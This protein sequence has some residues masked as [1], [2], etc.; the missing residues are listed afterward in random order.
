MSARK[1]FS[2]SG[3]VIPEDV[4]SPLLAMS[5]FRHAVATTSKQ[6]MQ[7]DDV[8]DLYWDSE[9]SEIA[10]DQSEVHEI[11][12][13]RSDT[14]FSYSGV[15]DNSE[16]NE[17]MSFSFTAAFFVKMTCHFH[18][19]VSRPS[20]SM[21][22][23]FSVLVGSKSSSGETRPLVSFGPQAL[24]VLESVST[25]QTAMTGWFRYFA[26]TRTMGHS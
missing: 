20:E 13:D 11:D 26:R 7:D 3:I 24:K 23:A 19:S 21:H 5:S 9:L 15:L 6:N 22:G 8:S 2:S 18:R 25:S 4:G 12:S 10:S 16:Q 1:T 17:G 14:N